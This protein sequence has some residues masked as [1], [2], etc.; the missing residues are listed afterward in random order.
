[1]LALIIGYGSIGQRHMRNL[2]MLMPEAKIIV[3]RRDKA[4]PVDGAIVVS[5]LQDALD[6]RPDIS[7]L[8]TPSGLHIDVLL[9]LIEAEIPTYVEKPVV[10]EIEHV[11][12]VRQALKAHPS[13]SHVTGFNLR[14]LSS[15]QIARTLIKNGAVGNIA[16]AN[17]S[18]GQWL[19]DWR[20]AS[21]FRQSY[22]ARKSD[23]GGVIFDLS[24]ELDAARFFLGE[25]QLEHCLAMQLPSLGIDAESAATMIGRT[26][27]RS[28][29]TVNVD[30][31]ARRPIRRYELV[32]D[33][34]TLIWDL[35]ARRLELHRPN[36]IELM[37]DQAEDFDVGKTYI[38][39]MR[40]FIAGISGTEDR[41]LQSL[42]DGL[43][44]TELAIAANGLERRQ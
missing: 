21:D 5:S 3:L 9:D 20:K 13:I 26:A 23:G 17:F 11:G 40:S 4:K 28:L 12:K 25:I 19:P 1:M 41:P 2:R 29:V 39:A 30:Y 24:H 6:M 33:E 35:P 27:D 31:V 7:V 16:R 42:D 15:M 32:G 34:G 44:S 22:S 18:A 14:L 43:R 10:I 36:E 8:A 38:E 37:T